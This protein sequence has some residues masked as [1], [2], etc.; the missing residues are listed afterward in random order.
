MQKKV[1]VRFDINPKVYSFLFDKDIKKGDFVIVETAFGQAF[2][3]VDSVE[4]FNEKDDDKYKTV[5]RVATN[6]D[7]KQNE[8]NQEKER[9]AISLTKELV[10]KNNL[11]M[12]VVNAEYSFDGSKVLIDF[13]SENRVDFRDLVKELATKLKTRIELRQIGVR[14]Q[15]KTV[16]GIG[17]CGRVCCCSS[18]LKDFGKVSIK[19]AKVQGLSLNPTKISGSCG[20]LMCCLEYENPY[21]SEIF[22]NIPKLN[23]EVST[24]DGKG[25]AVYT[26]ALKQI[27]SVKFTSKDGSTSYK[28]Y[29]LDKIKKL[30]N[31]NLQNN[32]EKDE[33]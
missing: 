1:N 30:H 21:Y 29:S 6:E 18:Y 32:K 23:S 4:D 25:V 27:V 8:L 28:D 33:E 26:N 9:K 12:D 19:M 13:I 20:R 11:E 7:V 16:G 10:E 24:P 22:P 15:A 5:L 17:V 3:K 14:D 31:Q 2:G